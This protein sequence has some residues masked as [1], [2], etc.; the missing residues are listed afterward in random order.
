MRLFVLALLISVPVLADEGLWLWN[1]F[2]AESVK[3]KHDFDVKP[4]FLNEL[5]LAS[6]RVGGEMGSFVSSG[7]L[8]LTTRQVANGCLAS[9][10]RPGHDLLQ[11]GFLA[12]DTASEIRCEGLDADVL[13]SLE[14]VTAQVTPLTKGAGQALA[15]RN[16]AI[17]RIEKDCAA[18]T[19]NV[20]SVVRLFAGGRY[21]LYQYK[22]HSEV[23]L[24]FAPEYSVAFF[25]KERDAITY[26]RYGLNVA[27][28][29][30]YENGRPAATPH[31]LKWGGEGVKDGDM[32]LES[33]SGV[34]SIRTPRRPLR[35]CDTALPVSSC[36]RASA[37]PVLSAFPTASVN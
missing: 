20:C 14:E 33:A 11:D 7:G 2:P 24:V 34:T 26:L 16:A 8:I 32:V 37:H 9:A 12:A 36:S 3:Q 35:S 19:G 4:A 15:Q 17:T 27:F 6:V 21:D 22:R 10:G 31:Y 28:L 1:Q 30:A 25:G 29:R 5:R 13:V 23:R 18:K